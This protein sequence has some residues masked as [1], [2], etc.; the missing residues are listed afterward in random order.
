D[1][2]LIAFENVRLAK[3]TKD[4]LEQQTA[5][6]DVL[7]VIGRATSDVQPVFQTIL[8]HS[9]RLC[10]ADRATIA[11]LEGDVIVTK[12]GW[13]IPPAAMEEYAREPLKVDRTSGSGRAMLEGRTLL[14]DDMSLDEGIS[15]R[16]QR[17]RGITGARSVMAVPL[18]RDG[19]A[20]G[21][22]NLRRSEV[23]P[24]TPQQVT[25]VE[26]RSTQI[27]DMHADPGYGPKDRISTERAILGV[28][29]KRADAIIGV[30]LLRRKRA[31]TFTPTQVALVETFA[32]QAVV[33]MENARL[34]NETKEGL[35][36]QT[37][38]SEVLKVISRSALDLQAVFDTVVQNSVRLC[39][40][41]NAS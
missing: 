9:G 41:D 34:F 5:V 35:E 32:D 2:A 30:I 13:N 16:M 39:T 37:A 28:P 27:E 31:S 4:A 3:E 33:A 15:V 21:A 18:L 40:A 11:L 29:L 14:W 38:T 7:A 19:V 10:D 23:R 1:Q 12:A 22:I 17:T 8:E 25:L 24:F 26:R 36:Q 20:M 6:A